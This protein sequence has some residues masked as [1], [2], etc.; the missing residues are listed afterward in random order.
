MSAVRALLDA[1]AAVALGAGAVLALVAAVGLHR[2]SD[3][4]SRM[5][6]ATKPATLGVVL[7]ALGAIIKLPDASDAAKIVVVVVL[8]LASAPVGAHLL[9]RAVQEI[10]SPPGDGSGE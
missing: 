2:L 6:A 1:T 4:L 5:H 9:G 10:E 3:T 8:Q 7:C